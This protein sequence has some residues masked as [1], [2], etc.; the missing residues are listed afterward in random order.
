MR[1]T[2]LVLVFVVI[3]AL[4]LRASGEEEP[5][6]GPTL[7]VTGDPVRVVMGANP[8]AATIETRTAAALADAA[9]SATDPRMQA[10]WQQ[11][12]GDTTSVE[13]MAVSAASRLS[14]DGAAALAYPMFAVDAGGERLTI[15]AMTVEIIPGRQGMA[16]SRD[17]EDGHAEVNDQIAL[18]CGPIVAA[19]SVARGLVGSALEHEI[20][21]TLNGHASRAHTVYHGMVEQARL[22][23]HLGAAK[24][25]AAE[26]AADGCG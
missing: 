24:R 10:G 26:V 19:A 13:A 23:D 3:A 17:H 2:L 20:I 25:A 6:Q 14:S 18:R 21:S 11:L 12:A 8:G 9:R 1:R 7:V 15:I 22:G 4:V 5:P 16:V